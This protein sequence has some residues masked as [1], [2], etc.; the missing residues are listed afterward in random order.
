MSHHITGGCSVAGELVSA[1]ALCTMRS[2]L[3]IQPDLLGVFVNGDRVM[4]LSDGAYFGDAALLWGVKSPYAIVTDSPCSFY[5]LTR[6][7]I[8]HMVVCV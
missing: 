2:F 6:C 5:V 8:S 4:T 7:V 1:S 3:L